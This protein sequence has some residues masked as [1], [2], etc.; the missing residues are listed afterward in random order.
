MAQNPGK[1]KQ[2]AADLIEIGTIVKPHG[3]K[4]AAVVRPHA[5][6]DSALEY[7]ENVFVGK[8]AET[9]TP[10]QILKASWMPKGW[11]VQLS[12]VSSDSAVNLLRGQLVFAQR[13]SLTEPEP[14]EYYI[15]DLIGADVVDP[16]GHSL[17]TLVGTLAVTSE[18]DA[19]TVETKGTQWSFPAI[20][21]FIEKVDTENKTIYLKNVGDLPLPENE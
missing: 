19:W 10:H 9:V 18:Q 1:S 3:F 8:T 20:S 13:S 21:H 14:G 6:K 7:V 15:H 17:G 11:K 16:D 12:Q 2:T 4:G 5:E